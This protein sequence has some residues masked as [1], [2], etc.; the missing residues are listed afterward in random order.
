M[1]GKYTESQKASIYRYRE[2]N[3]DKINEQAKKDYLKTKLSPEQAEKR[4]AYAKK[5]YQAKKDRLDQEY[6]ER[7]LSSGDL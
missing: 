1:S 2:A 3:R 6:W 7:I 5:Y 4:R